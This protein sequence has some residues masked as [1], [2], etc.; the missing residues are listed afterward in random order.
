MKNEPSHSSYLRAYEDGTD[1]SEKSAYKIQTPENYPE[2]SLQY[3]PSPTQPVVDQT[4]CFFSTTLLDV[5]AF[6]KFSVNIQD[7]SVAIISYYLY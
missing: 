3:W 5:S 2:E 1:C 4:I 6:N 7:D